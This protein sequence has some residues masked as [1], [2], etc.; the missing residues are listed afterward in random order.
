MVIAKPGLDGHDRGAKIIARALRDAGMEVI[1]TGLH[2]TPEQIVETAIQEDA[3]AVGVSILSGAHMTLVPRIVDGL[4]A[5]GADDVLVV[6]GGTIPP[7]DADEL[8]ANG[9]RGGLRPRRDDRRDRRL[10]ARRRRSL[11]QGL[12]TRSAG[13]NWHGSVNSDAIATKEPFRVPP[14]PDEPSV[15][16][17]IPCFNY[18]RFLPEAIESALGQTHVPLEVIVIDDGS[19]DDSHDVASRYV[20][21]VELLTQPNQGLVS[22]LNRGLNE[23]RGDYFVILS[24][25]DVLRSSYVETLL[26]A[27]LAQPEAAYAYSEMEYFGARTG[28]FP[29][30]P[31]SPALLLAGNYINATALTRRADA[32]A[33]GG[34]QPNPR[35]AWEDW[36]FWLRLLEAGRHGV[37]VSQPLLRYR[38]H[39]TTSR[40][41]PLA[42]VR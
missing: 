30:K 36:D 2:Q 7:D 27:L 35:N 3:D 14:N 17:I 10:P 34:F 26:A 12:R 23:A 21:S 42:G 5:Q 39:A 20:P 18:G 19:T 8:K 16:I 6:V 11:I 40:N 1:Y 29:A 25:D 15:S 22:V 41:P 31:F 24:A 9:R 33:V 4:R 38:R 37:P 13:G 32:L 28:V